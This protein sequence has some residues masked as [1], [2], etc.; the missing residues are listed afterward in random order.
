[1]LPLIQT[2]GGGAAP[3]AGSIPALS[4]WT[5][6]NQ[7]GGAA[8]STAVQNGSNNSG[9]IMVTVQDYTSQEWRILSQPVPASTPYKIQAL[10][11]GMYPS[12]NKFV[13]ENSQLAGLYF[14]DG[15]KIYGL[16]TLSQTAGIALRSHYGTTFSADTT[17]TN[18]TATGWPQAINAF[19]NALWYQL[20]ND[21]TYLYVDFSVDGY[22]YINL[23]SVA[24]SS[25]LTPTVVGVGGNSVGAGQNVFVNLMAWNV[26]GNA[27][28]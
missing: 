26:I 1:M 13:G 24:I 4:S 18:F 6:Y 23:G 3:P 9:P 16:E 17:D 19:V 21:G 5:W 28:L 7:T 10:I 14:S 2:G 25:T 22:N 12:T 15:T 11:R 27:T 20:R 8:G